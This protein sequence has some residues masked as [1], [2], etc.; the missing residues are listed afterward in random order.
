MA[1]IPIYERAIVEVEKQFDLARSYT[2]DAVTRT[3]ALLDALS[4]IGNELKEIETNVQIDDADFSID[5]F[6]ASGRPIA[7][8]TQVIIPTRPNAPPDLSVTM[9]LPSRPTGP[10]APSPSMTLPSL[11]IKPTK[12]TFTINMPTAPT[13][14]GFKTL[15]IGSIAVPDVDS[16][17]VK[18]SPINPAPLSYT[19]PLLTAVQAR[20][21]SSVQT[22]IDRPSI[23]TAKWNRSRE[24]DL[25][26]HQAMLDQKRAD[27][28]KSSLPLPDG[29]MMAAIEVEDIR[30]ANTY[31]DRSRDI[32]I[33]ESDLAI[34]VRDSAT[35]MSI[36]LDTTLMNF[37]N[38][39][40]ERI[41]QAS[42]ATVEAEIAVIN[43]QLGKVRVLT[44][45][46]Q[47][48]V[49]GKIAEAR[50]LVEIYGVEVTA[51][52][53]E[54]EAEISR[55][56]SISRLFATE[57]QAYQADISA[58]SAE[59]A[60][61]VSLVD[62]IF[63]IFAAKVQ[64]YQA[65]ISAY[66]VGVG[67]ESARVDAV[68]RAFL[69]AVQLYGANVGAFSAELGAEIARVDSDIKGFV[70]KTGLYGADVGAYQARAGVHTQILTA[71]IS[72][73]MA[74]A[75]LYLKNA[76]MQ[77]RQYEALNNIRI[78]VVKAEGAIVAQ[79]VAGALSSIHATADM[80]RSD[81]ASYSEDHNYDETKDD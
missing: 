29:A 70:A 69:G 54:V 81:S 78:E 71:Q 5:Q 63:K 59:T 7:P 50:A 77:I 39:V 9:D 52:R 11:P 56:D 46:Y 26:T 13:R 30:Y 53:A 48:L 25:L 64:A 15:D 3:I 31:D 42:R 23:E 79:Q 20:L 67:A 16:V 45:I 47:A 76:D 72:Q 1:D 6:D 40:Q 58:F 17:I 62:N 51:F 68:I 34:R 41:F 49:N 14:L 35:Q 2:T 4:E 24:R 57:V 38:T 27:W 43:A 74:R 55:V 36:Q 66:S 75:E 22:D 80:R 37:L 61:N 21:L 44:D 8:E 18:T 28:S 73:L 19:S 65:D 33:Q 32:A 10:S 12:P 60:A